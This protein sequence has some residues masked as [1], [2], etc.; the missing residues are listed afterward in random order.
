MLGRDL[1]LRLH[2][3]YRRLRAW[4]GFEA[5]TTRGLQEASCLGWI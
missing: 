1:R 3:D 4:A 2:D 5:S